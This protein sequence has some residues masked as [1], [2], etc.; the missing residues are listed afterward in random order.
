M[1]SRKTRGAISLQSV[2]VALDCMAERDPRPVLIRS[3]RPVPHRSGVLTTLHGS[4]HN[5]SSSKT[6]TQKSIIKVRLIKSLLESYTRKR[7]LQEG[8]KRKEKKIKQ[9]R[10]KCPY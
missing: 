7:E 2:V 5:V 3:V 8:S 10:T 9:R 1:S 6:T 4:F